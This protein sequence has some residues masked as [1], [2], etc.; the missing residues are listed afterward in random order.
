M[1]EDSK[2]QAAAALRETLTESIARCSAD[3]GSIRAKASAPRQPI[4]PA[5]QRS[6]TD[7]QP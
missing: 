6:A 2:H 5:T 3:I 1:N 4:E 7:V